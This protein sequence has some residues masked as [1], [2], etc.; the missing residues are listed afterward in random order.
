M[1]NKTDVR[2]WAFCGGLLGL[3]V[4]WGRLQAPWIGDGIRINTIE[5][6]AQA[7]GFALI[8]AILAY[9]RNRMWSR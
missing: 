3:L 6:V 4:T 5:L 1:K 8:A 2:V 9:I 7:G